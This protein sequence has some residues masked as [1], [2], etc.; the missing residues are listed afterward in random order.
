MTEAT[1]G[2]DLFSL[3]LR[4]LEAELTQ[5]FGAA[6]QQEPEA[7]R[8]HQHVAA[9]CELARTSLRKNPVVTTYTADIGLGIRLQGGQAVPLVFIESKPMPRDAVAV[10]MPQTAP[11]QEGISERWSMPIT[12][13]E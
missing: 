13:G 8:T 11:G 12:K 1:R 6:W 4:E 10:T 3:L 2:D 5:Q 9:F 7:V